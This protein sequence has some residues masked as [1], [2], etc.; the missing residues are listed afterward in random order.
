MGPADPRHAGSSQTRAWT[1]VPCIGRQILN[2]CTTRE[3]PRPHIL[4][5]HL[6]KMSRI[7]KFIDIES[8]LVIARGWREGNGEW[9]LIIMRFLLGWWKHSRISN[10]GCITPTVNILKTLDCTPKLYTL[11]WWVL[12][13]VNYNKAVIFLKIVTKSPFW[14]AK[15]WGRGSCKIDVVWFLTGCRIFTMI[16]LECSVFI[17]CILQLDLTYCIQSIRRKDHSSK[18]QGNWAVLSE[19]KKESAAASTP[20]TL[21]KIMFQIKQNSRN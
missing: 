2:H 14:V 21:S 18:Y 1:R 12:S 4:W 19:D 5:F 6:Y 17:L 16:F 20:W 10:D 7:G 8:I 15:K 9:L 3:A 11:E 13:Y